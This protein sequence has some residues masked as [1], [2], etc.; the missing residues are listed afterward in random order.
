MSLTTSDTVGTDIAGYRSV[1]RATTWSMT[2][3]SLNSITP[4]V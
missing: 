1:S 2:V 4:E 3:C